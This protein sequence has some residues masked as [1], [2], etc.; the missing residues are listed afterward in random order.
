MRDL[1]I[2]QRGERRQQVEA[3]EDKAD[4]RTPHPGALGVR[5]PREV[6]AVDGHGAGGGVGETAEYVKE[7][8][9]PRT[10]GANDG[11]E[12]AGL[13]RKV[14]VVQCVYFQL[15]GAIGF[16]EVLSEDDRSHWLL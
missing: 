4:A 2:A 14:D 10:G 1:D 16:T 13:D 6:G 9:L 7:S 12:L 11:D 8:R 3:L 15:A 5:E